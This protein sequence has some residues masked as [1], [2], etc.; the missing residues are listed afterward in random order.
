MHFILFNKL[1][2]AMK[3]KEYNDKEQQRKDKNTW[4]NVVPGQRSISESAAL[5]EAEANAQNTD[6]DNVSSTNMDPEPR[7]GSVRGERGDQ[8][9]QQLSSAEKK[10]SDGRRGGYPKN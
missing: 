3:S 5:S 10:R 6:C 1:Y 8:D 9:W 4:G 2:E 7:E